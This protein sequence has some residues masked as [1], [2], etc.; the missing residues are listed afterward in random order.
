MSA[1][2]IKIEF[3]ETNVFTRWPCGICD[4][5][6]EKDAILCEGL[7][8][9]DGGTVRVCWQ[10]LKSGNIDGRLEQMAQKM[11]RIAASARDM[12]GRVKAPT[13]AAWLA[14]CAINNIEYAHADGRDRVSG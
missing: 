13:Y 10:C 6:T 3:V 9:T 7:D 5:W 8:P 1:T 2:D 12:I 4:G 11:E 14:R